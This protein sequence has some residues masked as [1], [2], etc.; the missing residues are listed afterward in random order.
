MVPEVQPAIL[1]AVIKYVPNTG[2]KILQIYT[3][4]YRTSQKSLNVY[5]VFTLASIGIDDVQLRI[6][7]LKHK[8][9]FSELLRND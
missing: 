5:P 3:Q 1:G 4:L 2:F 8:L 9:N 6:L 7:N